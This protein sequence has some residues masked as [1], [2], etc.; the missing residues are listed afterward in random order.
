MLCRFGSGPFGRHVI[1]FSDTE[2]ATDGEG[3]FEGYVIPDMEV[4][5][6]LMTPPTGYSV[7]GSGQSVATADLTAPLPPIQIEK[8]DPTVVRVVDEDGKAVAGAKVSVT[9]AGAAMIDLPRPTDANG[10]THLRFRDRGEIAIVAA[11]TKDAA[12]EPFSFEPAEIKEPIVLKVSAK[13]ACVMRG[14]SG[15]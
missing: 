12:S 4:G 2:L 13:N 8:T 3:W 1:S 6:Q 11:V 7:M 5:A 15:R 9:G 14:P 10:E